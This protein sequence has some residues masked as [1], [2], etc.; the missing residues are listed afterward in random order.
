MVLQTSFVNIFLFYAIAQGE[1]IIDIA[2]ICF[3]TNAVLPLES[4]P[5]HLWESMALMYGTYGTLLTKHTN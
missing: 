1:Q 3:S 4:M 5:W 2:K